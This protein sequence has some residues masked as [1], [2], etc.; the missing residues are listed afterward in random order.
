[1]TGNQFV[2]DE[3][4]VFDGDNMTMSN[5]ET[6]FTVKLGPDTPLT[7]D[8]AAKVSQGIVPEGA[9]E[10]TGAA[11]LQKTP[12]S[13]IETALADTQQALQN[14]QVRQRSEI[15]S[16]RSCYNGA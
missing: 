1:M 3:N 11:S 16:R 4:I 2:V 14:I 9:T 7:G 6:G 5:T 12:P 15:K 8:A 13:G 10:V